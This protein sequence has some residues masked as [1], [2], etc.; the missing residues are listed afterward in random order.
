MIRAKVAPIKITIITIISKFIY[1]SITAILATI[2]I[3]AGIESLSEI[4]FIL[5]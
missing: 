3:L 1:V 5:Q 2:F 4:I